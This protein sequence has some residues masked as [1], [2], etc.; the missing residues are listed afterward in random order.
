MKRLI[1]SV[2]RQA[3]RDSAGR[4]L[5]SASAQPAELLKE[6]LPVSTGYR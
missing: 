5:M 1:F 2:F 6:F 4:T 3:Q